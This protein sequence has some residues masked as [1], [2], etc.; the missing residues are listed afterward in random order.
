MEN[1][2]DFA[3]EMFEENEGWAVFLELLELAEGV[4]VEH[5]G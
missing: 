4:E 2:I 3:D 1:V 5:A